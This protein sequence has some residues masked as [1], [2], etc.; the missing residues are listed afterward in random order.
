MTLVS[1][2]AGHADTTLISRKLMAYKFRLLLPVQRSPSLSTW[3]PNDMPPRSPRLAS[4]S[5]SLP[6]DVSGTSNANA[7]PLPSSA[8]FSVPDLVRANSLVWSW[9]S[10]AK[11]SLPDRND[12]AESAGHDG[13]GEARQLCLDVEH[14][15]VTAQPS[16]FG[17]EFNRCCATFNHRK[18][19]V[20]EN[21]NDSTWRNFTS[22]VPMPRTCTLPLV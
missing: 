11:M 4:S 21:A 7:K 9:S 6:M 20:L 16:T 1:G 13:L 8:S 14:S 12:L 5:T 17:A 15:S 3:N 19:N 22:H 10:N 2:Y 18:A